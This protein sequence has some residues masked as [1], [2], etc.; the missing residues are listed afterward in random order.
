MITKKENPQES[1]NRPSVQLDTL[2]RLL[3]DMKPDEDADSGSGWAKMEKLL[4]KEELE[5]SEL[6]K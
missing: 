4:D 2:F 5:I 1:S 3:R 6:K